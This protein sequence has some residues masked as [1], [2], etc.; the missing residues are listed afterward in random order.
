MGILGG[1]ASLV[2]SLSSVSLGF[3]SDGVG[4]P[5]GEVVPEELHDGGR[6]LVRV[7]VQSVELSDGV[8]ERLQ[9]TTLHS[10]HLFPIASISIFPISQPAW[11]TGTLYRGS[12]PL[13][14]RRQ[15]S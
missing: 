13:H 14:R 2:G 5:E 6:I 9:K 4:G 10:I 12:W 11:P 15:S 7:L 3:I 8:I 1:R